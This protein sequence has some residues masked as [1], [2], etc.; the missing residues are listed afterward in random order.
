MY[1][2]AFNDNKNIR[3]V[4]ATYADECSYH[5]YEIEVD[6]RDG[7]MNELAKNDIYAGVHYRD[8]TEYSLYSYDHGKCPN[9][10]RV[11]QRI[12][13]LPL[14]LWLTDDDVKKIIEI[15]NGYCK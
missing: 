5:L 6:D 7:L 14:H 10:H 3:I 8:N 2:D 9:A 1:N 11:S 4:G 12:I 15:V 13:T